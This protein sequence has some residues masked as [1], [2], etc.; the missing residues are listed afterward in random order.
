MTR[1]TVML[2]EDLKLCVQE[3]ARGQR[4][5]DDP[6]FAQ[7]PRYAG[8]AEEDLAAE[9]DRYLYDGGA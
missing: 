1:T 3:R 7:V 9:H 5:E 8:P 6:L 2:P 4:P